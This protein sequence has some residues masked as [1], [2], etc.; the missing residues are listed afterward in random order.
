M[1]DIFVPQD[2][3]GYTSY[4]SKAINQKLTMKFA[5]KS[6]KNFGSSNAFVPIILSTV[7]RINWGMIISS[8]VTRSAAKMLTAK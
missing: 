6:I 7:V 3:T 2:T 8:P 5:T 1:P 4:F